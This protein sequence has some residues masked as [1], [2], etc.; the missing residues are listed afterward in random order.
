ML[1]IDIIL[2]FQLFE[3]SLREEYSNSSVKTS[4]KREAESLPDDFKNE[5][6]S[7]E[8]HENKS[9]EE[10]YHNQK[11]TRL[12]DIRYMDKI[13]E[14]KA[15]NQLNDNSS[16]NESSS[17]VFEVS[18][19][20]N[21]LNKIRKIYKD[22]NKL[23]NGCCCELFHNTMVDM[24]HEEHKLRM[25]LLQEEKSSKLEEHK[26]RMKLLELE[27]KVL[28][29]KMINSSNLEEHVNTQYKNRPIDD[30][31]LDSNET[32]RNNTFLLSLLQTQLL[33]KDH[34]TNDQTNH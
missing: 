25:S 5:N 12:S 13:D 27:Y 14:Q 8:T 34:L 1:L 21:T 9:N 24:L 19:T 17:E 18:R 4:Y 29:E 23:S 11:R 16:D 30:N 7:S 31:S 10:F 22:S 26:I 6:Y 32:F 2:Y 20:H 15:L 3:L 28:A 33:N